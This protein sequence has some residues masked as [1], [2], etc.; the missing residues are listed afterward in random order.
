MNSKYPASGRTLRDFLLAFALLAGV[1]ALLFFPSFLPGK[2]LFSNDGPLGAQVNQSRHLPEAFSG[3]WADLNT[4][5]IVEGTSG[6]S[7]TYGLRWLLGAVGFAKFYP[8]LALLLLGLAAWFFFRQLRLSH[9]A[10]RLGALAAALNSGFFSSA[11]WGVAPHEVALAFDFLA[12]SALA[13][14]SGPGR[15]LRTIL[16][17]M[18]VGMSIGEG[19]D[20]AALCS[21]VIAV[22]I[23]YQAFAEGEALRGWKTWATAF[24]RLAVVVVVAF[25][26]VGQ[27]LALLVSLNVKQ[28]AGM[29]QDASTRAQRWDWATQWSLPKREALS[30]VAPGVFGYR[31]DARDGGYYWGAIGRDPAWDRYFESNKQGPTPTGMMRYSGGGCYAGVLVVTIALWS[32]LRAFRKK[33]PEAVAAMNAS[34]ICPAGIPSAESCRRWIWFWSAATIVSLLLAFGRF[35]P[36]YQVLYALPYASAVRNPVKFL[37]IVEFSLVILFAYGIDTLFQCYLAPASQSESA[38]QEGIRASLK[39]LWNSGRSF[40]G[41]WV[42]SSLVVVQISLAALGVYFLVRDPLVTY[43]GDVDFNAGEAAAIASFSIRQSA[44]AIL[45]LALSASLLALVLSG[46]FRGTRTRMGC[47][48]IGLM[49][50]LDLGR[51]NLPWIVYWDY[52][53]KYAT[54]PILDMLRSRPYEHRVAIMSRPDLPEFLLL[55]Q[56]YRIE[57]LPHHFQYYNIQALDVVQ[58][59]TKPI[60]LVAF[61]NALRFDGTSNTLHLIARRW[62][63]TNTRYLLG[64]AASMK[65]LNEV[66]G[67]AAGQFRVLQRFEIVP[68]PGL[69]QETYQCEDLVVRSNPNGPYALFEFAGA[70][71]RA[72]LYENWQV[73]ADDQAALD[74]LANPNFDPNTTVLLDRPIPASFLPSGTNASASQVEYV[75][76]APKHITL[77]AQ[78]S[79]PSVLLLSDRIAPDWTVLVDGKPAEMLRCNYIMRGVALSPGEHQVEFRFEM[80]TGMHYMSL[81]L[82]LLGLALCAVLVWRYLDHRMTSGPTPPL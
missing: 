43:L 27:G 7:V 9:L 35:A 30:L 56:L 79:R 32:A 39:R 66:I 48:V 52:P 41:I 74:Q 20:Q 42:K 50:V 47:M 31:M 28:A 11:C 70:L 63:L 61:E 59:R 58:M 45:F 23:L 64:A 49:L 4:I 6:V 40:E 71:P 65:N 60:D 33:K 68:K 34:S 72:R 24:G 12:L 16:A 1:L 37:S 77:R 5:G 44:W 69:K 25:C 78:A 3:I 17:G 80:P 62:Q 13:C 19:I 46:W 53:S 15:W 2:V 36:F 54:N 10:C 8:P 81:A 22:F 14:T 55:D 57:W 21:V 38:P 18:A 29:E 75:S 82:V 26:M 73:P 76:Y 67:R 51:A